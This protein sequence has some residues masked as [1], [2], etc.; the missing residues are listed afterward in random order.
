MIKNET[1]LKERIAKLEKKLEIEDDEN[2]NFSTLMQKFMVN[3]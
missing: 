1:Q 3:V 2:N